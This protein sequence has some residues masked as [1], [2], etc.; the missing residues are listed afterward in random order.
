MAM[1]PSSL[2]H[3]LVYSLNHLFDNETRAQRT[4]NENSVHRTNKA[5]NSSSNSCPE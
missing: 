2:E 4:N 1:G 3:Y 5:D